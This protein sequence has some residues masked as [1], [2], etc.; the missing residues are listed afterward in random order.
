[1]NIFVLIILLF[2]VGIIFMKIIKENGFHQNERIL[3]K[4]VHLIDGNGNE[5]NNY[6]VFIKNGI[7][8]QISEK[9]MKKDMSKIV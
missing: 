3:I 5:Y 1:M 6:N 8:S 2:V 4:N 9:E 7:I